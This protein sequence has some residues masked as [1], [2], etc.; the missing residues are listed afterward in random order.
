MEARHPADIENAFAVM[1][2][3]RVQAITPPT[4][5]AKQATTTIPIVMIGIGDPVG[6]RA[7]ATLGPALQVPLD[8]A[9]CP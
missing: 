7:C 3:E 9:S 4:S 6:G 8:L 5:A 1:A 2:K